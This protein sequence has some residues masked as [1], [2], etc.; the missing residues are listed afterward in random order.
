[1]PKFATWINGA[2]SAKIARVAL[3]G[4]YLKVVESREEGY[5]KLSEFLPFAVDAATTEDV[6]VNL[7]RIERVSFRDSQSIKLNRICSWGV[8]RFTLNSF[9]MSSDALPVISEV[10]ALRAVACDQDFNTDAMP[11]DPLITAQESGLLL[12]ELKDQA[13]KFLARGDHAAKL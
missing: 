7:N 8:K 12:T 4:R 9:S 13:I 2:N 1:M 11:P 10:I 3:G 5:A 6:A